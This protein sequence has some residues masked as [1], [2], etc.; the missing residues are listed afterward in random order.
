MSYTLLT[1]DEIITFLTSNVVM[2]GDNEYPKGI[3]YS[4]NVPGAPRPTE[5]VYDAN[6]VYFLG[7]DDK[8]V[9]YTGPLDI[10][11]ADRISIVNKIM[12]AT[13]GRA[14][15]FESAK[16]Y[17][18]TTP[19]E[20]NPDGSVVEDEYYVGN[21]TLVLGKGTAGSADYSIIQGVDL[22]GL[23][24]SK[25]LMAVGYRTNITNSGNVIGALSKSIVD[26]VHGALLLSGDSII[27]NDDG[28]GY[29]IKNSSGIAVLARNYNRNT[30]G[31]VTN[32]HASVVFGIGSGGIVSNTEAS[33]VATRDAVNGLYNSVFLSSGS[34][35]ISSSSNVFAAGY[36]NFNLHSVSSAL[37]LG[38]GNNSN[39][40]GAVDYSLIASGEF[41][42]GPS[43][44][45]IKF[46][47]ET[48]AGSVSNIVALGETSYVDGYTRNLISIGNSHYIEQW[49][50]YMG[51]QAHDTDL[52]GDGIVIGDNVTVG[53][54]S[55][56]YSLVG[57]RQYFGTGIT[58]VIAYGNGFNSCLGQSGV[59]TYDYG[60]HGYTP[61]S[62][63]E[64]RDII[65]NRTYDIKASSDLYVVL[66][67]GTI[68]LNDQTV[69]L[70]DNGI[71]SYIYIQYD[72]NTQQYSLVTANGIGGVVDSTIRHVTVS[73]FEEMLKFPASDMVGIKYVLHGDNAA[74][75]VEYGG[76][77][78]N[79]DSSGITSY[80]EVIETYTPD[81]NN[82]TD[83]S[84]GTFTY[85]IKLGSFDYSVAKWD[86]LYGPMP[87]NIHNLLSVGDKNGLMSDATDSVFIG[88]GI[89]LMSAKISSSI[90]IDHD[91][92]LGSFESCHV[93]GTG[94]REYRPHE[95]SGVFWYR[96]DANQFLANKGALN[97][98]DAGGG[99][100]E[101]HTH[102]Y[103]DAFAFVN[104]NFSNPM[105]FG[106]F[107]NPCSTMGGFSEDDAVRGKANKPDTNMIYTGGI[108]LG[109]RGDG[110]GYGLMKVG[111]LYM[112]D[113]KYLT[114]V[115]T[116]NDFNVDNNVVL[117][118]GTAECPYAGMPLAVKSIQEY[119]G[120]FR[121]G[122]GKIDA[123][124]VNIKSIG[125][126]LTAAG[127]GGGVKTMYG[128][129]CYISA[130]QV[131]PDYGV[132][133]KDIAGSEKYY[134]ELE[135]KDGWIYQAYFPASRDTDTTKIYGYL[136]LADPTADDVGKQFIMSLP[137]PVGYLQNGS[138]SMVLY[139]CLYS[140][141]YTDIGCP[142]A[143]DKYAFILPPLPC[144][145]N[146]DMDIL[147]T[148]AN[149]IVLPNVDLNY[150]LNKEYK[151]NA[152]GYVSSADS[153][154]HGMSGQGIITV[155]YVS[156]SVK[157]SY[158]VKITV[159]KVPKYSIGSDSSSHWINPG[160][161][162][163]WDYCY[164]V[165]PMSPFFYPTL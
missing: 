109:G 107:T 42:I 47:V 38:S 21:D 14:H 106:I 53:Y 18:D 23:K 126:A 76:V 133:Q 157:Y 131:G 64:L 81:A 36:G 83:V 159:V 79:L 154:V 98:L 77:I 73:D 74:H 17:K 9:R 2:N 33:I 119:D 30:L 13:S 39:S 132:T 136:K 129:S 150:Y 19:V 123:R 155:D 113:A 51:V 75:K 105:F 104:S 40:T 37:L 128:C 94:P 62:A 135:P 124:G 111:D 97:A 16:I 86:D 69:T 118:P 49:N 152:I 139:K 151:S 163:N 93:S 27:D 96:T 137:Y 46:G 6:A 122:V 31:A 63:D 91:L 57:S 134:Y 108:A 121:I 95:L 4:Y 165:E 8:Y 43:V 146:N 70:N 78:I 99:G 84:K 82:P 115:W 88:D 61:I 22:Y 138:S 142:G 149:G 3:H 141:R 140:P 153:Q 25:Y 26:N 120:T 65:S 11:V 20:A 127:F 116:T 15:T 125:E 12:A 144:A 158:L 102:D 103:S 44:S 110:S 41:N 164:L 162:D 52:H 50:P 60:H 55:S 85:S 71:T 58:N 24:T 5:G 148:A 67:T 28:N 160:D 101:Y 66:G 10:K 92:E 89:A 161:P 80:I 1:S 56:R 130:S 29:S 72:A 100:T 147:G 54:N 156:D 34:G 117:T 45:E 68:T 90:I 32:A 143:T 87:N 112:Y 48:T 7:S 114:N 59:R 145:P 35:N